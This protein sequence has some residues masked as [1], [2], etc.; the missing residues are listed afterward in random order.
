MKNV[1]VEP[2]NFG[3]VTQLR[4]QWIKMWNS[5]GDRI[6]K[7]PQW[8]QEIVLEDVNTAIRNRIATMEMIQQNAKRKHD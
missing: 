3:R 4:R 7:M 8:M 2:L 1:E 5:L 6:L